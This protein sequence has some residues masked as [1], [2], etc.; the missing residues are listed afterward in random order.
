MFN[1][2]LVANR[3]EIAVRVMNACHTLGIP[4]V[5]VY[6]K[7]DTNSRHR[8]EANESVFIGE[9]PPRES[10]LDI[11]KII[12][13]AKET[14]CD[15]I[16]PGYGFLSENTLLPKRCAEEGITFIGPSPEAML[17]MGNKVESRIKMADAG[18]PLIPGMKGS[19]AD[20]AA[21]EKA[22]D[23]A[24]FPVM[25]KA[26]AGGGGKGMRVVHERAE[27]LDAVEAAKREAA[28]AF[29]DDT[30]YLEKY[31]S[32]PRHIEFQVIADSHGNCVHVFER[33]CSIQ[34]RHQKIIEETPS[35][36]LTDEIRAKMGADAVKVAKAANYVNAG[37]VE[38]LFDTSG[39]YYFLEMNTRIQVEHPITEMVTG[40]DLVVE[41]IR[42][43]AGLPLS[44]GFMKL[45]QRGHAIE[46]RIYAEDGE[47]N[48]MPS[49]GKIVHYTE[50]VGPGIRV[51]SGVQLGSEVT[52]DYDPIMAKLIVHAPSRDLAIQKMIAALNNYKILGVKTSKR[53]MIDCL[54]HPEFAAGRTY[55]SFIESHMNERQS[56]DN[57]LRD[58]ALA[59]ASVATARKVSSTSGA[60]DDA[61]SGT[62][63]TPWQM[64]GNWQI[65]DRINEPV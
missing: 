38:F 7:A 64:I 47:N 41:Q 16:H 13:A 40:A 11:D 21:F 49:T 57:D 23:E 25:I 53:F 5:A 33:E 19:G 46:C 36:A 9:A 39:N 28:N 3:S 51:D 26:A 24:G 65:G 15:A 8:R 10:Y 63:P 1:K 48:F 55:T 52:I 62:A 20:M 14:G 44:D 31:V 42:I 50:P 45:N 17:L 22:A 18:V 12:A 2:I 4:C 29:G 58:A 32:N 43:A 61:T 54:A 27:L 30:V 60:G 56:I 6:S 35:V 59:A 37:T 34:R